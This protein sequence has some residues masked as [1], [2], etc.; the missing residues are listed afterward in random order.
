[1]D[2]QLVFLGTA[3]GCGVPSFFCGCAACQEAAAQP[4]FFRSRSSLLIQ[5]EKNTLIDA[6]PDLRA[7][8]IRERLDEIDHF[9][10]THWHFDHS[11]GLGEL[12]FYVRV[13]R[14]ETITAYM[15]AETEDWLKTSYW[16]LQDCLSIQVMDTGW[17]V[18]ADNLQYTALKVSH[19]PGTI[20]LLIETPDG[21][22]YRLSPGHRSA[23]RRHSGAFTRHRYF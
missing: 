11:G 17:Q 7:Q 1:M 16:F 2:H 5:G 10:L 18:E 4:N 21:A 23:A 20:G 19:T 3:A 8:L 9:F 12:E 13:K 15:T 22:S 14:Q 6:P